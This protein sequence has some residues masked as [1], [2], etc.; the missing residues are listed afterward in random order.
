MLVKLVQ[1]SSPDEVGHDDAKVAPP[2]PATVTDTA[3]AA[4]RIDVAPLN[5]AVTVT[6]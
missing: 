4:V 1:A 5:R 2:P 3:V 6:D